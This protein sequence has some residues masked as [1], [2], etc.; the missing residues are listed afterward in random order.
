MSFSSWLR[1]WKSSLART[2]AGRSR[3]NTSR[4]A[5]EPLE[6]RILMPRW[7][8]E[9][10]FRSKWLG[11]RKSRSTPQESGRSRPVPLTV[12]ELE[13]RCVLSSSSV[14]SVLAAGEV[15]VT[16]TDLSDTI[17]IRQ[18]SDVLFVNYVTRDGG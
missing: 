1:S 16:G 8:T 6:T 12:M 2:S 7:F 4:L 17:D 5:V 9:A 15:R 10:G 13:T 11:R 14:T 3:G 18:V